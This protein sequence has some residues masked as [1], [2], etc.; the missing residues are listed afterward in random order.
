MS[1]L[2][3]NKENKR[4]S[5]SKFIG[6]SPNTF[7]YTELTPLSKTASEIS[8]IKDIIDGELR[9]G[10][11][12]TKNAF[13]TESGN[14]EIVHLATHANSGSEPWV[15]FSDA[16][17]DAKELYTFK[18]QS[19]LIVLSACNTSTGVVARGEGVMSL[20]RGFFYAGANSVVST[21]WNVSD[22]AASFIMKDFYKELAA[23]NSKSESLQAAKLNYLNTHSLSDASPYYWASFVLIGETAATP[24]K[25][26][27]TL[28]VILLVVFGSML[29][30]FLLR[31]KRNQN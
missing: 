26:N 3:H 6:Y 11:K 17:L 9:L 18:T 22:Q 12:A 28:G 7:P 20:A 29:F 21:L 5:T 14:Y 13:L 2:M 24:V 15:A 23:G 10:E 25:P 31:R 4:N 16:K 27:F 19:D 8:S 30:F 1:F